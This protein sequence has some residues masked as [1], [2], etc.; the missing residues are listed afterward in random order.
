MGS[1]PPAG[2]FGGR[3]FGYRN[4]AAVLAAAGA[5]GL[6]ANAFADMPVNTTWAGLYIGGNIGHGWGQEKRT[7]LSAL[8]AWFPAVGRSEW[9]TPEGTLGGGQIG[10]NWQSS[11][12]V[13]GVEF[14]FEAG[15]L[16]DTQPASYLG[17]AGV[18]GPGSTVS[19][20]ISSLYTATARIG[21]DVNGWLP[22]VKGGF[23][24]GKVKTRFFSPSEPASPA[25]T[26]QFEN[27]RRTNGWTLGVGVEVM[28]MANWTLGLEYDHISLNKSTVAGNTLDSLP[29]IVGAE[30]Y[31]V[32]AKINALMLRANYKF[33]P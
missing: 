24:S 27:N 12:W 16:K 2:L 9:T 7:N 30:N 14:M 18:V 21:Y 17:N 29:Q 32:R 19:S 3:M 5:I 8:S 11:R 1:S 26:A 25:F 10:Y 31:D 4:L 6:P 20:E 13:L 15:K 22:Y 23:A 28:T 33:G